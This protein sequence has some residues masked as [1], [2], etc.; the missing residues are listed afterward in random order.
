[1]GRPGLELI[2]IYELDQVPRNFPIIIAKK[3]GGSTVV[4]LE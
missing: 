3:R 1:M 4:D 2:K